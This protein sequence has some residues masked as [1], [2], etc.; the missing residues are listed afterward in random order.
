MKS[1]HDA[2]ARCAT[3]AVLAAAALVTTAA[4]GQAVALSD[5]AG[6][7][8]RASVEAFVGSEPG[9]ASVLVVRDGVATTA[10]VGNATSRG[11]L[12]TPE[13]RFRVGSISKM[14]VAAMV[15]QL[16]AE[17]RV[18]LD[19]PLSTY[20][21]DTTVGADVPIRA[22]LRNR[23]GLANYAC[24]EDFVVDSFEDPTR[25]FTPAE[26]LGYLSDAPVAEPDTQ[27]E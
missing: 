1:L 3:T 24:D 10:V 8:L 17:G 21:P 22:L 16:V 20:L 4:P 26:L 12:I 25:V 13:T 14:F 5:S 7:E 15:M 6:D 11:D 18:D 19:L 9:G 2:L 23:S 27:F